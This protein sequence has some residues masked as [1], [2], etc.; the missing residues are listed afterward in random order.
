[1]AFSGGLGMEI[2]L[3]RVITGEQIIRNDEILF[4]E[5]NTRFLVEV[6]KARKNDFEKIMKQSPSPWWGCEA[7]PLCGPV[8]GRRGEERVRGNLFAEIGKVTGNRF[9]KVYGLEGRL[10]L[11]AGLAELKE[12]WQRPFKGW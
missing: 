6:P 9:L 8:Q 12:A 11:K 3:A 5:S 2:N 4:S 1:M 10:V 7:H